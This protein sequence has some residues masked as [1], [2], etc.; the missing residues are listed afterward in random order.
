MILSF[1]S[2]TL[3]YIDKNQI[4]Y[5]LLR[6]LR[7]VLLRK[8]YALRKKQ[9]IRENQTMERLLREISNN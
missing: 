6:K 1:V 5:V 7:N 2:N 3:E 9:N 4:H 8:M